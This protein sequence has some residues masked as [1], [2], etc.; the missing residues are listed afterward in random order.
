MFGEGGN[1]FPIIFSLSGGEKSRG[2]KKGKKDKKGKNQGYLLFFVLFAFFVS[3]VLLYPRDWIYWRVVEIIR[4]GERGFS[5][6]TS[7]EPT[8]DFARYSMGRVDD[9]YCLRTP[10]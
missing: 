1:S 5:V 2:N 3:P 10:Q 6:D 4:R 7:A 9:S 8:L